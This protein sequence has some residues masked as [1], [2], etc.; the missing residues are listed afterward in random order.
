MRRLIGPALCALALA[1]T[2]PLCAQAQDYPK[3]PV[4]IVV[5]FA[6]GGTDDTGA[7][8]IAPFLEKELGVPVVVVSRPGAGM[9]IALEYAWSRPHDGQTLLWNNQQYLSTIET[10]DPQIPY[11]TDHWVWLEMLQNDPT[12]IVVRSNS[13]WDSLQKLAEDMKARPNTITVGLLTGSVQ[14]LACQRLFDGIL[15][16]KFREVPQQSGGPMRTSLVG[17]HLDMICTNSSETYSLGDEVR[18]LAVFSDRRSKLLPNAIPVNEILPS[19]GS[20]EKI[21]EL[22]AVRGLAVPKPFVDKNPQAF[23]KLQKAYRA[24]VDS[25]GYKAWLKETGRD[26]VTQSLSMEESN[27]AIQKYN[28]FFAQHKETLLGK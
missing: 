10:T 5:G 26:A 14:R 23:A 13:K 17:G 11:R 1:I 28:A 3:G 12:V 19:L 8:G 22:G 20:S 21:P 6:P 25:E 2:M 7:R 24:A 18:A 15:N 9:Q 4:S 16:V 27:A